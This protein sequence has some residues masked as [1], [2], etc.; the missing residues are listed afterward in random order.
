MEEE[1][2]EEE[3]ERRRRRRRRRRGKVSPKAQRWRNNFHH[4]R[5]G[6]RVEINN[7]P[8]K[9][10][11]AFQF[12]VFFVDWLMVVEGRKRKITVFFCL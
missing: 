3:E 2:E 11:E 9:I 12:L 5:E 8:R 1:E 4:V 10:F 7:D 6:E